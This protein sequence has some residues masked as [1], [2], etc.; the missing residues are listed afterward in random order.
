MRCPRCGATNPDT[1][2]WC[3]Q[4]FGR[5]SEDAPEPAE[6]QEIP[7]DA[8]DVVASEAPAAP[9]VAAGRRGFRRQGDDIQWACPRCEHFNPIDLQH[10]E[11][12]GSAFIERLRD[13]EPE[14][15]RDWRA[16]VA[17]SAL[18]P[19]AGHVAVGRHSSGIARL[20]LFAGWL[21]GA[22]ALGGSGGSRAVTVVAPLLLG[23]LVLWAGSLV[24]LHRLQR[25]DKELL[26]GRPLLWLVLAVLTLMGIGLFASVGG[27]AG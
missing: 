7:S 24:D 21:L 11:V 9:P 25:G 15:S 8:H 18:A 1:A 5:F 26:S 19:G 2:Q 12:C 16:A 3:G 27:R 10:C 14:P 6:A 4:C 17:L 13:D 22:I 20:V 23:A